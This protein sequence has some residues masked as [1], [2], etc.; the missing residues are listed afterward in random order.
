MIAVDW[1]TSSLRAYRMEGAVIRE[2]VALPHGILHLPGSFAETLQDAIG[3]WLAQDPCVLMSG[4]VGSRQGWVEAPYL[5]CPAGVAAL[6]GAVVRVPFA[7]AVVLLVPGLVDR[8]GVPE[9]MRGEE[10]ELF[11]VMPEGLA[12]LPGTHTKWVR[13]DGGQVQRFSTHMTGEVFA[14]LRNHTILGRLMQDGP[15]DAAAFARGVRRAGEAGGLLHHLFGVRTLALMDQ[16]A[17]AAGTSYLSGLLLG[18]E[19]IHA[20]PDGPV[21]LIGAPALCDRY[22]EALALLGHASVSAAPDAAARGLAAIGA[23]APWN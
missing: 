19:I 22:A 10:T 21:T 11:G 12:C 16:L 14:A 18:H 23:L 8:A 7:A 6:A 17:P 5:P 2:R 15:H 1:G 20:A 3:P 13:M 9:V 4:M